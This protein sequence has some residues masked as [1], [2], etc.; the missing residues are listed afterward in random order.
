MFLHAGFWHLFGSFLAGSLLL[1]WMFGNRV[2]N[3]FGPW[4]FSLVYLA[5]GLG[6]NLLH[7]VFNSTSSIPCVGAS[8]AISSIVGCFFVLFPK[9]NFDLVIYFRLMTL[10][11]IHTHTQAAIGAWIAE[12]TLLGL[13][14][15]ALGPSSVAFWAHVGGFAVGLA[16]GGVA[17]LV[18]PKKS[19]WHSTEPNLVSARSFQSRPR[20]LHTAETLGARWIA[21]RESCG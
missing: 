17:L 14:T 12:Q 8:G 20:R 16:M 9:A 7:Y 1:R 6:G 19:V 2:E 10:K 21:Y 11:T 5:C 13:L 4:L 18:I 3:T 15:Q